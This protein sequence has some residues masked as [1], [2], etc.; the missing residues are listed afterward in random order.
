MKQLINDQLLKTSLIQPVVLLFLATS[1]LTACG[2][3]DKLKEVGK[4]PAQSEIVNPAAKNGYMPVSM[5]M[6]APNT[7]QRQANSLWTGSQK[8]FFKDQRAGTVGDILTV[9]IDI[10][11]RGE[12][13]NETTRTRSAGEGLAVPKLFGLEASAGELLPEAVDPTNLASATSNSSSRGNGEIEREEQIEMRLAATITQVL[14]NGNLVLSGTQ[15]VRVNF[16][17]RIL[18]LD[19][20]IRPEDISTGNSVNYDQIAEARISYGG[21]GHLTDLQQPRY[22]QQVYEALSPF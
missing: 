10:D 14:P 6:P 12:M 4:A 20:V 5:P 11:D 19:G 15:E 1:S 9:V 18:R 2:T 22:G 8:G 3:V 7:Y 17:N 16:E 13:S 21:K